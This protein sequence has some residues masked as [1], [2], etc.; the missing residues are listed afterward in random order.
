MGHIFISYAKKDKYWA[1]ML[2]R[3]LKAR[4][5]NTWIDVEKI[6]PSRDLFSVIEKA[7]RESEIFVV[8]LTEDVNKNENSF[9]HN[10]IQ[11]A[12]FINLQRLKKN[13]TL[14]IIPIVFPGGELPIN[15]CTYDSIYI[16]DKSDYKIQ[17]NSIL[18]R[19]VK[20]FSIQSD[21]EN[22]NR[23]LFDRKNVSSQEPSINF[24]L[25]QSKSRF[26]KTGLKKS[27]MQSKPHFAIGI[28]GHM[29]HGKTQ[30]VSAITKV[31]K[32][33]GLSEFY[34]F[35]VLDGTKEEKETGIT[36]Y[37]S[38]AY[39]ETKDRSY[40]IWDLPGHRDYI[41][42]TTTH[43][44]N[45]DCAILVVDS[46]EGPMPQTY[47]HT[48]IAKSMMEE[49]KLIIFI[50]GV[51]KSA[52]HKQLSLLEAR[53]REIA[54]GYGFKGEEISIIRG[55]AGQV[56]ESKSTDLSAP[57]YKSINELMDV[58]D[59]TISLKA[60]RHEKPLKILIEDVFDINK[61]GLVVVGLIEQGHIH[62][63]DKVEIVGYR[64]I[65]LSAYVTGLEMSH[66]SCDAAKS[67]D[68]IGILLR[69]ISKKD[70]HKGM[71]LTKPGLL[72]SHQK[73]LAQ[74]YILSREEGGHKNGFDNGF[75]SYFF[76]GNIEIMGTI[77]LK[78]NL[79]KARPG[80]RVD[81]EVNLILPYPIYP[82]MKFVF[83]DNGVTTGIGVIESI[84]K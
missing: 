83:R 60:N 75:R 24:D 28:I 63:G 13:Q 39:T 8:C 30:L 26:S 45:V 33:K 79:P 48:M 36:I 29:D 61:P 51:N 64:D 40:I 15:I 81:I 59:N 49:P 44:S 78:N 34:G 14:P 10:E 57:D 71:V 56:L 55:N 53:L 76:L 80:T 38:A 73:F 25:R 65:N 41:S 5:L 35:D 22:D 58:I 27:S 12:I 54:T 23:L 52:N 9:V 77:T 1:H 50:N 68:N 3:D 66:K 21:I 70:I 69:G 20:Y 42:N 31:Q 18:N 47:E 82:G 6:P 62:V 16:K 46:L 74:A 37:A 11:K 2:N 7:I 17:F 72:S 84:F 32:L 4:G 19:V 43:L 67:G